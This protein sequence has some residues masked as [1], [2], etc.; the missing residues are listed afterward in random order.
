MDEFVRKKGLDTSFP[1]KNV[2]S[3]VRRRNA[4][5]FHRFQDTVP[6]QVLTFSLHKIPVFLG[7]L[8]NFVFAKLVVDT[9]FDY[10]G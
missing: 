5:I 2:I 10:I 4:S 7:R 9:V 1:H 6:G 8:F 3:I